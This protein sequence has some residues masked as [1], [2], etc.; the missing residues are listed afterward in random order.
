MFAVFGVLVLVGVFWWWAGIDGGWEVG[1]NKEVM[2]TEIEKGELAGIAK[3]LGWNSAN[4]VRMAN[5]SV[6]PKFLIKQVKITYIDFPQPYFNQTI[7]QGASV[8]ASMNTVWSWGTLNIFVHVDKS[9]LRNTADEQKKQFLVTHQIIRIINY[10]VHPELDNNQ[11]M[12]LDAQVYAKYRN[13]P[14]L[15][16]GVL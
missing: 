5:G 9:L 16:V 14:I 10:M 12:N 15:K 3:D 2:M 13:K 4:T 11:L 7:S 1:S 6:I 8:F